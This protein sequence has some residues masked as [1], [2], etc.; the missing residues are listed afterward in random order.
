MIVR[1]GLGFVLG[2][3]WL[4]GGFFSLFSLLWLINVAF[5]ILWIVGLIGAINGEE[6]PIPI[7]GPI[8]QNMFAGM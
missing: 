5:F 4:S 8:A 7:I 2:V 6:R 3:L 1:Y